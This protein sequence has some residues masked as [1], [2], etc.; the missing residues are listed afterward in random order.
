M[1]IK[2]IVKDLAWRIYRK[3]LYSQNDY[4]YNT[5]IKH[6]KKG[7]MDPSFPAE[8]YEKDINPYFLKY[9]FKFSRLESEY[10]SQCTG[11]KSD[12]YI[13]ATFWVRC[14]YPFLNKYEWRIGYC[15]K[16]MFYRFINL[17]EARK[18]I[19]ILMP[20]TIV[21]CANGRYFKGNDFLCNKQAAID[22]V[23]SY[24]KDFIIKPT[25]DSCHGQGICKIR[26]SEINQSKILQLFNDYGEDFTIQKVVIQHPDLAAYNPT[27]VNTIRITTYQ[28]F[29]GKVKVLYASQRFGSKG[30]VYDNADDPN[31]DG[32]FCVINDD[33]T[34]NREVHHYRNMKITRLDDSIQGV[35][36]CFDKVKA[37][38]LYLHTLFPQ[39]ALIGWD[40]T[41][42]PEGHPL[43]IEYNFAPGL[44]TCQLA[45]GPMFS[46]EDLDEIMER[47]KNCYI[48]YLPRQRVVF[49]NKKSNSFFGR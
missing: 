16:N 26:G 25:L 49:P 30:K 29:E 43:M 21:C 48:T 15:D 13:P 41:V 28:D 19:D 12:L 47:L 7:F 22:E 9:G 32:G 11:V 44:G 42:T 23:C 35:T 36:P 38:V 46:K 31:G 20:E 10:C 14:L 8:K 3:T 24:G 34:V 17:E 5:S 37:A 18:H 39:F 1:N 45:H 40:M 27:S 33:G 4:F 2:K 6:F